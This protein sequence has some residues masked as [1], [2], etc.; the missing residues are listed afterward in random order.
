M[1]IGRLNL[2]LIPGF[3]DLFCVL[4]LLFQ[5]KSESLGEVKGGVQTARFCEDSIFISDIFTCLWMPSFSGELPLE[6]T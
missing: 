6:M 2:S 3:L 1:K 5:P 4:Q